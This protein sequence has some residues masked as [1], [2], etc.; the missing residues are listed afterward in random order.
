[1]IIIMLN[2]IMPCTFNL[3]NRRSVVFLS[4]CIQ[5]VCMMHANVCIVCPMYYHN[6]CIHLSNEFSIW[7]EIL[8]T[9]L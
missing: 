2:I 8:G 1:M 7:K 5:L 6:R 3:K 4:L 9:C